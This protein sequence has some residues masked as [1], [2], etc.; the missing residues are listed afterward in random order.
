[1]PKGKYSGKDLDQ[2]HSKLLDEQSQLK[3]TYQECYKYYIPESQDIVNGSNAQSI[4][5]LPFDTIGIQAAIALASGIF[6]N[7]INMGDEFFSYRISDEKIKDS[8]EACDFM[9]KAGKKALEILQGSNFALE[10]FELI[11]SWITLNTGVQYTDYINR[12]F[13]C[14][15][16]SIAECCISE[17]E[18]GKVDTVFREFKLTAKQ[19]FG[20]WGEACS[21]KVKKDAISP[22]N[23]FN[24]HEFIHAVMP[25]M[26]R[27]EEKVDAVNMPHASYYY[28]KEEKHI[29]EESG[30]NTFPYHVPRFYRKS[31]SPY[32][33]GPSFTLLPTIREVCELRAGILDGI[34][35]KLQPPVFLPGQSDSAD[36][37]LSPGAV[38]HYDAT[39]GKPMFLPV[40]VDINSAASYRMEIKKEIEEMFFVDLFRMLEDQKNMTATEVTERVAEKVQAITPVINRLYNEYFSPLLER[41][42]DIMISEGL[43]GEVPQIISQSDYSVEY[44]TKLENK[45]RALDTSQIMTAMD[46]VGMVYEKAQIPGVSEV[47]NIDKVVKGIIKN[48]N[49][50]PDYVRSDK[51]T[52]ELRAAKAEQQQKA[53]M[54]EG[55]KGMIQ[56]M[57]LSK[58]PEEGSPMAD[59]NMSIPGVS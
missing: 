51:E 32:G 11:Q 10:A 24:K 4:N 15:N 3:G 59:E 20:K 48:N 35:L 54:Q 18:N 30:Y 6:S 36:V 46:Q 43:L 41:L 47:I 45:L 40:D 50:D 25:R 53:A 28:E 27:D 13:R 37:D 38:N 34:Q 16:F 8:D 42:F 29:L 39:K 57:D 5:D 9:T 33:R 55:L 21:D 52:E 7:T 58:A 44:S 14:K 17:D 26:D 2:M 49:I 1:M 31:T 19:A 56:P 12:K 22:E 23:M